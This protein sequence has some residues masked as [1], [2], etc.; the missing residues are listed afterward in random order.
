M[1]I[2]ETPSQKPSRPLDARA[3]KAEGPHWNMNQ[4]IKNG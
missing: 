4:G 1:E 3:E 2:N